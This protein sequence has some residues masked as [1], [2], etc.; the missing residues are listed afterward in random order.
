MYWY[1]PTQ[2]Y[3]RFTTFNIP[4]RRIYP[5]FGLF[6]I[7]SFG[8]LIHTNQQRLKGAFVNEGLRGSS[9]GVPGVQYDIVEEWQPPSDWDP[10]RPVWEDFPRYENYHFSA[11]RSSVLNNTRNEQRFGSSIANLTNLH[12]QPIKASPRSYTPYPNFDSREYRNR[13]DGQYVSC[14]GPRGSR[15]NE[16]LDDSVIGYAGFPNGTCATLPIT[17]NAHIL[18]QVSHHLI[19]ALPTCLALILRCAS[20]AMVDLGHTACSQRTGH[21]ELPRNPRRQ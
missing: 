11:V 16:S 18:P 5:A 2:T 20:T 12:G 14:V 8:L 10:V 4:R 13:Y 17:Q 7:I 6:I 9:G 15:L 21:P 19:L 1:R 3:D